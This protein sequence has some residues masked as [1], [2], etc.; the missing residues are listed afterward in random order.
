VIGPRCTVE[1]HT[2]E[3]A[4]AREIGDAGCLIVRPD[5]HVA[6]RS[7]T[8]AADSAAELRRVFNSLLAR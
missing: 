4:R 1:D 2:G 8:S 7:E 3:W 6:W 5:H